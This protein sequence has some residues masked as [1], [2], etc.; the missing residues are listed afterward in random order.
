MKKIILLLF[1]IAPMIVFAQVNDYSIKGTFANTAKSGKVFLTYNAKGNTNK[2]SAVVIEGKFELKGKV[3]S[4]YRAY[5]E[6]IPGASGSGMKHAKKDIKLFYIEP[7]NIIFKIQDSLKNA[8]I[9]GSQATSDEIK[10]RDIL[11]PVSG[12]IFNERVRY[13]KVDKEAANADSIKKTIENELVA[14]AKTR[15]SLVTKFIEEN[16][17]SYLSL[18]AIRDVAGAYLDGEEAPI[19]YN[20]ISPRIKNTADGK[21]FAS[22]L[23]GVDRTR[24]GRVAPEFVQPDTA[25]KLIK[26]S[27]FKGKYVLVDFWAS[28]CHPCREENP[29]VLKAYN[30]YKSKDFTVVGISI[31]QEKMRTLWLKAIKDDG[32]PWTQLIDPSGDPKGAAAVYGVKAIPSNFLIGPDGKIIARNLRGDNLE[33]KLNELLD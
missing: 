9:S 24:V 5:L 30:K 19:L 23:N 14:L 15:T 13:S 17:D 20:R 33:E 32:M 4:A 28:W 2:D 25:G 11:L 29:R 3:S 12:R 1:T 10:L 22:I 8:I 27:D 26:L 16:P 7:A 6:F 21:E 18:W 31:D